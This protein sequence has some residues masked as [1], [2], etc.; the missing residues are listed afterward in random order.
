MRTVTVHAIANLMVRYD[1][2]HDVL[3]GRA[4]WRETTDDERWAA[5][6]ASF[7]VRLVQVRTERTRRQGQVGGPAEYQAMRNTEAWDKPWRK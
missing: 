6:Q 1:S 7:V 3:P 5:G 2:G 4:P